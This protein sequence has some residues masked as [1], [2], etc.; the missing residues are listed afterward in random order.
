[1]NISK[2]V[3]VNSQIDDSATGMTIGQ[4]AAI[5][6][7][8]VET[9]RYYQRE[10]LLPTPK[11]ILGSIRRYSEKELHCLQ[12][13]KR[14]QAIGFSL[15]EITLLIH[16]AEEEHCLDTQ[17]LAEKKLVVIRQKLA[18][19]LSIKS[20]LEKLIS[21]CKKGGDGC[22]CPIIDSLVNGKG[23]TPPEKIAS[24]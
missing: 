16:L 19:F 14:A 20:T 17:A 4:L 1:M 2:T 10:K 5:V 8:N 11:R 24:L 23:T 21:A 22:R 9:I 13:I 6:G 15:A 7:V 3:F 18:D 12:F